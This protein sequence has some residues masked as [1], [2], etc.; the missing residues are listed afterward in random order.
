MTQNPIDWMWA[1]ARERIDEA[2]GAA[3]S[4]AAMVAVT[5]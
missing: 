1:Q 5:A 3:L 2:I 4:P